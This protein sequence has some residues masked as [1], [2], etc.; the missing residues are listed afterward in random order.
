[1]TEPSRDEALAAV[2][3]ALAHPARIAILRALARG[4]RACCGEIVGL[5]PLA[6][7]TVSQHLQ[8]LREAGLIRG[9]FEGRRSR[10]CLD[11]A[12]VAMLSEGAADLFAALVSAADT[13]AAEHG[14]NAGAAAVEACCDGPETAVGSRP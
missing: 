6:Q 13:C 7:S 5:L 1:M 10:Y 2:F 3:K 12:T 8:V 9:E 14:R 4:E 11:G